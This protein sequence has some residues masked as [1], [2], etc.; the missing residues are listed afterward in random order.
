MLP[1]WYWSHQAILAPMRSTNRSLSRRESPIKVGIH[2]IAGDHE[3][4]NDQS[5][6]I[7]RDGTRQ[8]DDLRHCSRPHPGCSYIALISSSWPYLGFITSPFPRLISS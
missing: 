2:G 6:G 1:R 5:I 7:S 3:E 8:E 4:Q